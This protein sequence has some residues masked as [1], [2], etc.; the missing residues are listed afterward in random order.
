MSGPLLLAC[1]LLA[2]EGG[3]RLQ[4]RLNGAVLA[5]PVLIAVM[6]MIL[7]LKA[8]GTSADV[9]FAAVQPLNLLLGPAT[10]ALGLPLY[11]SASSI[12]QAIVPIL[13]GVLVGGTVAA[14]SVV[15]I[16][17]V[18]GASVP[19][20]YMIASK[21]VTAAISMGIAREIGGDPQLAA[22]LS[23]ITG[24]SGAVICVRVLDLAGVSDPRARGLAAGV[25]AHGIGTAR[26][27]AESPQAGAFAGLAMGLTGFAGGVLMPLVVEIVRGAGH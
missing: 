21:S 4:R 9:Y 13:I 20:L 26:M 27:L 16:A 6:T 7:L 11:R 24:I 3:V 18:L 17:S 12:R 25:A 2:F 8:T 22:A 14:V 15:A 5:N 10:V 1:T 19:L 23:V